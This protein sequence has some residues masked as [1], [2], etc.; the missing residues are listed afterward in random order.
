[1]TALREDYVSELKT[2]KDVYSSLWI[3]Q[4]ELEDTADIRVKG[5]NEDNRKTDRMER[6]IFSTRLSSIFE[7]R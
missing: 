4:I 5:E 6:T 1:M 3:E 7:S 2:N